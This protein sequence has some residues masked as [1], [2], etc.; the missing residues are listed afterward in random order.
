MGCRSRLG[1]SEAVEKWFCDATG[2]DSW[3]DGNPAGV[4]DDN[5]LPR[6]HRL[7][8]KRRFTTR[9]GLGN[10]A[11]D[12][13]GTRSSCLVVSPTEGA[14]HHPGGDRWSAPRP[15][16]ARNLLDW[17]AAD[18]VGSTSH[19][20]GTDGCRGGSLPARSGC[21]CPWERPRSSESRC[22]FSG[23]PSYRAVG[24]ETRCTLRSRRRGQFSSTMPKAAENSARNARY[25]SDARG[26]RSAWAA[27][28]C[29]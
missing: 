21:L 23:L 10:R 11:S 4:G 24:G 20:W 27:I 2:F 19:R 28:P 22:W 9:H 3:S 5:A 13:C 16:L 8:G 15:G 1:A 25:P 12:V 6:P 18:R 26:L 29:T 7:S 14:E 17:P